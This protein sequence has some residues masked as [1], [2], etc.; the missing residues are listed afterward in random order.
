VKNHDF[1]PKN[2]IFSN[3]RGDAHR[4]RPPPW[5]RPWLGLYFNKNYLLTYN[6]RNRLTIIHVWNK[7]N[8]PKMTEFLVR[9]LPHL[10]ERML[11]P[12]GSVL[13][14]RVIRC[15]LTDWYGA[16]V[17]LIV[18]EGRNIHCHIRLCQGC[19]NHVK[20]TEIVDQGSLV[21]RMSHTEQES[22]NNER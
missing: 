19:Q 10:P 4:V 1:T 9:Q 16:A 2:H 6:I 17:A 15:I 11:R 14:I 8:P 5:I 21:F 13:C 22:I 3:F 12:C 7:N 20:T 18:I